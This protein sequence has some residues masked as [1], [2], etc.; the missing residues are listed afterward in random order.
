MV[1][2]R[3]LLAE[4]VVSGFLDNGF[5]LVYRTL[6][7]LDGVAA[8]V[9]FDFPP[10]GIWETADNSLIPQKGQVIF[11]KQGAGRMRYGNDVIEISPGATAHTMWEMREA[12]TAPQSVRI[13]LTYRTPVDAVIHIRTNRGVTPAV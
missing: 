2:S 8:Q 6:D 13:L 9:A 7:G 4:T 12:Q 10:G 1:K 3:P 5:N 11:L